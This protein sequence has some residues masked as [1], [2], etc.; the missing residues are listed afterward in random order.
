MSDDD[1]DSGSISVTLMLY[2]VWCLLVFL[3]FLMS[4]WFAWSTDTM[5]SS[6][7][8]GVYVSGPNHK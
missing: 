7:S 6:R 8:T 1:D 4:A 2:A 3:V 5:S